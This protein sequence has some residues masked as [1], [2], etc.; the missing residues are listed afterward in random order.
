LGASTFAQTGVFDE[1]LAKV[2]QMLGI[3][4]ASIGAARYA[5]KQV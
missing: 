5:K 4:I 1:E 2:V 3:M